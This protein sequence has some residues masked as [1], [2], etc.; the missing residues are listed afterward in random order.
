MN[1][2][3]VVLLMI[4]IALIVIGFRGKQDNAISALMGKKYGKTNL[5]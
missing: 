5:T 2:V 1:P 4:G 3:G